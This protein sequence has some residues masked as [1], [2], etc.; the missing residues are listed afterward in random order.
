M[1]FERAT[2]IAVVIVGRAIIICKAIQKRRNEPIESTKQIKNE[3]KRIRATTREMFN[4]NFLIGHHKLFCI[5]G[6]PIIFL[7]TICI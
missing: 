5:F 4:I 6:A 1:L 3:A 7:L 2:T